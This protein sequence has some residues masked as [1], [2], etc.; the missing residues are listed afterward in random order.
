MEQIGPH[1]LRQGGATDGQSLI[2]DNTT[3]KWIPGPS[4][5]TAE[6]A[7]DQLARKNLAIAMA[8]CF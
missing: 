8:I 5:A 3:G 6:Y 4:T 2:W 1:Q 7:A